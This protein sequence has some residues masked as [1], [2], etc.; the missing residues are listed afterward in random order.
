MP[1]HFVRFGCPMTWCTFGHSAQHTTYIVNNRV[2]KKEAKN[3]KT[4]Y[5]FLNALHRSND[6]ETIRHMLDGIFVQKHNVKLRKK[7][8]IFIL[9][10][11]SRATLKLR[12]KYDFF[13]FCE[14]RWVERK[15]R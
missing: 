10:A 11:T 7:R 12:T 5:S 8:G 15:R 2:W 13:G 1:F 3:R 6:R 14:S 4:C 9:A